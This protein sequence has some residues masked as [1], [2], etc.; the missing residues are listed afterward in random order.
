MSSLNI[1]PNRLRGEEDSK[2]KDRK[3]NLNLDLLAWCLE[4]VPQKI[5]PNG[6][7]MGIYQGK[8]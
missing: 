1:F 2:K 6:G 8:K 4:K 5:I 7:L 3:R